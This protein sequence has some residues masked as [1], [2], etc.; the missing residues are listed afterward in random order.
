MVTLMDRIFEKENLRFIG[1]LLF[2][3]YFMYE[4][5]STLTALNSTYEISQPF[6]N[7]MTA[8]ATVTKIS[9]YNRSR[10]TVEFADEKG[11]QQTARALAYN[12]EFVKAG[13]KYYVSYYPDNNITHV[14]V[15]SLGMSDESYHGL[16]GMF[17]VWI[18]G[19]LCV[20]PIAFYKRF[21]NKTPKA[22]KV[23]S[24]STREYRVGT[25]YSRLFILASLY[26]MFLFFVLFA[27]AVLIH[28]LE[29]IGSHYGMPISD[30]VAEKLLHLWIAFMVV[31]IA[32]EFIRVLLNDPLVV[33]AR[34]ISLYGDKPIPWT[35]LSQIK[36]AENSDG[37]MS[38]RLILA[39]QKDAS[40]P[41]MS[42]WQLPLIKLRPVVYLNLYTT[43]YDKLDTIE[44]IN[45]FGLRAIDPDAALT[46]ASSLEESGF[47]EQSLNKS[48]NTDA[49]SEEKA[50]QPS[51]PEEKTKDDYYMSNGFH[52]HQR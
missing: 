51:T 34:G 25:S 49:D 41:G 47:I 32:P 46:L 12:V 21:G 13:D 11:R 36:F 44:A 24:N 50:D 35:E 37:R 7:G 22:T 33:S 5:V 1:M 2:G 4:A 18:A 29:M 27:G 48:T 17:F 8:M 43:R 16:R 15:P 31:A 42:V 23:F 3:L 19:A 40:T 39:L 52:L 20:F 6:E 10:I 9:Q 28:V 30:S 45:H 26:S 38:E 14:R